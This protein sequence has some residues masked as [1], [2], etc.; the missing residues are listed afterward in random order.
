[1]NRHPCQEL[2]KRILN[3]YLKVV[4]MAKNINILLVEDEPL[5]VKDL[6]YSLNQMGFPWVEIAHSGEAAIIALKNKQF[7]LVLV[8]I[9]L[10]GKMDGIQLAEYISKNHN[11]PF[12]YLTSQT[13]EKTMSR[14][15]KTFPKA[16]LQK[17]IDTNQLYVNIELSL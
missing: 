14:I 8:D 2:G 17:P 12:I 3:I 10:A 11:T 16:I 5:I 9:V 1:M 15:K 4:V 7:D 6:K 13:D